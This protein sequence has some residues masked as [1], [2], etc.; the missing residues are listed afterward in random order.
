MRTHM[1][2]EEADKNLMKNPEF[3]KLW[4]ANAAKREITVTIMKER[5]AKKL[6]QTQLAH[7]AGVGRAS[8]ARI[9]SGGASPSVATLGRIAGALGK[10]L[11]VRFV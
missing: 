2:I 8:V 7:K 4:E 5:L 3:K 1:T 9:E 6:S 10:R 11:E